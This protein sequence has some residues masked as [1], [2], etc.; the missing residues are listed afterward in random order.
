MISS[1]PLTA[2]NYDVALNLVETWFAQKQTIINAHM[3]SLLK[4]QGRTSMMDVKKLKACS[5]LVQ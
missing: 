2:T 4:L 5:L 3:E 1:F